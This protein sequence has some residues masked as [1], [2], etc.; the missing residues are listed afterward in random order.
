MGLG[1]DVTIAMRSHHSLCQAARLDRCSQES[2]MGKKSRLEAVIEIA[3]PDITAPS[4]EN[5]PQRMVCYLRR[6]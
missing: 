2:P 6:P 4:L 3:K 1:R 5:G